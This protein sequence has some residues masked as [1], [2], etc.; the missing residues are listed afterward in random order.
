MDELL[1]G[2]VIDSPLDE[3]G[4]MQ[5]ASLAERI[6]DRIDC[7]YLA[8]SPRARTRQTAAAIASRTN[9]DVHACARLDELD[10][11]EWSGHAFGA[12]EADPRWRHWNSNRSE[13]T[14][15]G[16]ES[17]QSVQQRV[18]GQLLELKTRFPGQ[19]I[20]VVTHSEIIRSLVLQC[21]DLSADLYARIRIDPASVTTINL[22]D[23]YAQIESLNER[24]L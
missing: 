6:V 1:L 17:I 19:S 9:C 12:L 7:P 3:H 14:T 8:V 16:G 10:F 2:R 18:F 13:A 15:P 4:L 11:G 24:L 22:F 23:D 21:L 20:G 5:A